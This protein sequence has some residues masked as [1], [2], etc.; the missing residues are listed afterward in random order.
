MKITLLT[1]AYNAEKTITRTLVSVANQTYPD[2]EHIIVDGKSTDHTVTIVRS[3]PHV[4]KYISEPD[5]G[6]YDA[7]NKGIGLATG[8]YIGTL[9]ADDQLSDSQVIAKIVNEIKTDAKDVYFGDIRFVK[10]DNPAKTL[11]YYSSANFHPSKFAKGYMPAHPS[12]YIKRTLF[13]KYGL[14]KT[15]YSIAA[16]YELLIRFLHNAGVSYRYLPLLIVDMLPGGRSNK[17]AWSRY[18]LNKEIVR[19]CQENGIK[20]NMLTLSFKYFRKIFEYFPFLK[21]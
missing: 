11:R 10:T 18:L 19:G 21:R 9:N 6:M 12:V 15:D 3:F 20:T 1:V 5:Q 7:L 14:Y 13:A 2:I 4:A 8:D 17:S 16:D